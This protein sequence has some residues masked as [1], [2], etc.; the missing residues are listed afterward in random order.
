[1]HAPTHTE[2]E[3][4]I[5]AEIVIGATSIVHVL[6]VVHDPVSQN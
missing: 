4:L 3:K 1:M 5:G 6:G 2:D